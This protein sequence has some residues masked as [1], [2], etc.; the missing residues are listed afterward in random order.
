[1]S[2]LHWQLSPFQPHLSPDMVHV[3]RASL[4]L[5]SRDRVAFQ[6]T[7]APDE[8]DR[9]RRFIVPEARDRFVVARGLLR[10]ILGRYLAI[11]PG[12]VS[13]ASGRNGKPELAGAGGRAGLRFNMS[14]SQG[15][16]LYAVALDR[17]TGVDLEHVRAGLDFEAIAHRCFARRELAAFRSVPEDRQ[18][19]A[20]YQWWTRKEAYLKARGDGLVDGLDLIDVSPLLNEVASRPGLLADREAAVEWSLMDV[21]VH[22]RFVAALAVEGYGWHITC[23][24]WFEQNRIG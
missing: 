8:L 11:D 23:W 14:H 5:P 19:E 20:F 15:L 21:R 22:P 1:M 10:S 13:L 24:Q 3:W 17:E 16:A 18:A 9:A 12:D 6:E 7:L 4:D 2:D